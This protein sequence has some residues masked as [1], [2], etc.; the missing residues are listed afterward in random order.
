MAAEVDYE[1]LKPKIGKN[2]E[3]QNFYPQN[4][5]LRKELTGGKEYFFILR[6][7][8]FSSKHN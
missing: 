5:P 7:I 3:R 6:T 8:S 1:Y 4:I 2:N